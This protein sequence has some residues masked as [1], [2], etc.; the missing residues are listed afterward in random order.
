MIWNI[1]NWMLELEEYFVVR[2]IPQ[3]PDV[4]SEKPF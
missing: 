1:M 4:L 3:M 2:D